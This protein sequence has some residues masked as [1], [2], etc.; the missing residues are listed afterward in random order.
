M[1]SIN[2]TN[3]AK[4]TRDVKTG[5]VYDSRTAAAQAVAPEF[6]IDPSSPDVWNEVVSQCQPGRFVDVASGLP[7][8]RSGRV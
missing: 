7:I 4:R 6:A 2:K 5:I 3:D 8:K 1:A